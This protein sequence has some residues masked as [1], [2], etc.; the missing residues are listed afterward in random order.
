MTELVDSYPVVSHLD[1]LVSLDRESIDHLVGR[2]FEDKS[3]SDKTIMTAI[4]FAESGG[5]VNIIHDNYASG[6]QAEDSV[7]RW[8]YGLAQINSQ[9]DYNR[10]PLLTNPAYNLGAARSIFDRQGFGAWSAFN[11][12]RY[13]EFLLAGNTWITGFLEGVTEILE[14]LEGDRKRVGVEAMMSHLQA[15]YPAFYRAYID[16]H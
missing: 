3:D 16:T 6:H 9:H 15:E 1:A 10:I 5:A 8:D 12:G 14:T 11:S 7:A 13:R 4:I 2:F